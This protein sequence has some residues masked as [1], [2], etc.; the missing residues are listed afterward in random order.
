MPALEEEPWPDNVTSSSKY[1]VTTYKFDNTVYADYVPE[2][3]EGYQ[4]SVIDTVEENITT[5]KIIGEGLPTLIRFGAYYTYEEIEVLQ[6]P[7][8]IYRHFSAISNLTS[9]IWP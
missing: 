5:R 6:R 4:Y 9:T 1:H 2:F 7:L 3:N 8:L